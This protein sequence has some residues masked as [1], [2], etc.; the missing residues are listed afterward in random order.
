MSETE[1]VKYNKIHLHRGSHITNDMSPSNFIIWILRRS[2][3]R[4]ICFR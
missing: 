2:R 3:C 4:R 1:Q